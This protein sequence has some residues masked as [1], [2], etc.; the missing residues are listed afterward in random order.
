MSVSVNIT[1]SVDIEDEV[2]NALKSYMTA[3]CRPLPAD[4]TT[5]S[6]LIT[7]VGGSDA[8]QIDTF[9]VTLDAR[10]ADEATANETLR[11]AIGLMRKAAKEQTTAI[12]HIEVNS[13]GSWGSDPVRPDLSMYSA[14][15]R[16]VA[17]LENKTITV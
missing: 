10:A 12:R 5:P 11:N 1:R 3:Y 2:R 15:I 6:V 9:D 13:S 4:F 7:L 16:V 14:R 17:H 8:N